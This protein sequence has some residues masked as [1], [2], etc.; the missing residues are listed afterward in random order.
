MKTINNVIS[1]CQV[2]L[3]FLIKIFLI[4]LSLTP[5]FNYFILLI[6]AIV[7][8]LVLLFCLKVC[9]LLVY[10][11]CTSP[12]FRCSVCSYD[13]FFTHRGSL[14]SLLEHLREIRTAKDF[15]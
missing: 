12:L 8:E 6:Y 14:Y 5:F 4:M 13:S 15:S 3:T 1:L 10:C 9:F 11:A 2:I 7:R